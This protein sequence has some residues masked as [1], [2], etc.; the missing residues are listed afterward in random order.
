MISF[1]SHFLSSFLQ[2]PMQEL[3]SQ[4]PEERTDLLKKLIFPEQEN[5]ECV[6]DCEVK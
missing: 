6:Q 5:F 4:T 2:V 1:V 3:V